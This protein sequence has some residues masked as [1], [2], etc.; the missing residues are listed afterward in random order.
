M[1]AKYMG[2]Q[3]EEYEDKETK[4]P[5]YAYLLQLHDG[6]AVHTVRVDEALH[7]K[8]TAIPVFTDVEVEA[9]LVTR[10]FGRSVFTITGLAPLPNGKAG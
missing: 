1:Q 8:C 5:A 7:R 2:A 3:I 4:R 6:K 9:Q 10:G